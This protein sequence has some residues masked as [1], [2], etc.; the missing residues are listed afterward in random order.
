M[1]QVPFFCVHTDLIMNL[2]TGIALLGSWTCVHGLSLKR[3]VDLT[4]HV[5]LFI[6]TQGSV[7]GTSYN[8]GNVFPGPSYP[9]GAVKPGIDTTL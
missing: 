5:N 3:T 9:F 7:P 2:V 1:I 8:G 4:Q 6:G